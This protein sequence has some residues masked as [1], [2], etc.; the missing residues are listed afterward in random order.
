M[1]AEAAAGKS[2]HQQLRA[3]A[4]ARKAAEAAQHAGKHVEGKSAK[5][6]DTAET[7]PS[8]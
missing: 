2:K 3:Q 5:E 1:V 8:S 7:K 6:K 4:K